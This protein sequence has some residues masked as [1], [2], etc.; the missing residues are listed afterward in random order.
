M[1]MISYLILSL[2]ISPLFANE[3]IE[4]YYELV[5][6]VSNYYSSNW[7]LPYAVIGVKQKLEVN[8]C[9]VYL[10]T[11]WQDELLFRDIYDLSHSKP[12]LRKKSPYQTHELSFGTLSIMKRRT[13]LHFMEEQKRDQVHQDLKELY[14]IC[15]DDDL[16]AALIDRKNE[17]YTPPLF[18]GRLPL[19]RAETRGEIQN[20]K[21]NNW[22]AP[23]KGPESF[24]QRVKHIQKAKKS[25]SYQTLDFSGDPTGIKIG[26]ELI[27]KREQGLQIRVMADGLSNLFPTSTKTILRNTKILYHNMM[28]SGI[29]VF[30][31]SCKGRIIANEFRGIDLDKLLRRAHEKFIIFDAGTSNQAAIMGG[32]NTHFKYFRAA[33]PGKDNWRDYDILVSGEIVDEINS[34]FNRNFKDRKIRY[35]N[36]KYD[37]SCLNPYDPIKEKAQ[38][39][40]F[41]ME[42][43]KPYLLPRREKD[44]IV[45]QQ[46]RNRLKEILGDKSFESALNWTLSNRA[47]FI[48]AR[49]EENENFITDAHIDLIRS[50]RREI[51]IANQFFVPSEEIKTALRDAANR[52][53]K[54]KIITNSN[55]VNTL[56]ELMV[57]VGRYHYIDI[58]LSRHP[59]NHGRYDYDWNP[60]NVEIYEF[61]GRKSEDDEHKM[62]WY[63]T[64][65]MTIDGVVTLIGSY[66]LDYSSQRNSESSMLIESRE[67]T[68]QF[69]EWFNEDIVHSERVDYQQLYEYR[70]PPNGGYRFKLKF[71]LKIERFL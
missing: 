26:E 5:D 59:W 13:T 45:D 19:G 21:N 58:V 69:N 39:V 18:D 25:I 62:G 8:L 68:N 32:I 30:G 66:N 23:L 7:T 17:E 9:D 48:L 53:V 38:Y 28:V 29:R 44:Q 20:R 49:P 27:K 54:I 70:E 1:R 47:R 42:K 60:K 46:I 55:K 40:Q 52:G 35:K 10:K 34:A 4:R 36:Y 24:Y 11:Y 16:K 56:G 67:I 57:I 2:L 33:A 14:K 12:R 37:Q 15:R 31:Y 43:S 51:I 64:K 3:K 71:G 22:F 50:A 63:H 41:R 6:K 61:V 65:M